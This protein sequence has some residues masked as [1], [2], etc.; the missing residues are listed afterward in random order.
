M[1]NVTPEEIASPSMRAFNLIQT[2]TQRPNSVFFYPAGLNDGRPLRHFAS[3]CRTFISCDAALDEVN[4]DL[5]AMVGADLIGQ[6]EEIVINGELGLGIEDHPEW[7]LRY[8]A[9]A[10]LRGYLETNQIIRQAGR[11]RA[12]PGANLRQGE[13]SN[14]DDARRRKSHFFMLVCVCRGFIKGLEGGERRVGKQPPGK[15]TAQVGRPERF[16]KIL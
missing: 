15:K 16:L 14:G 4:L 1:P 13:A 10:H 9:P 8:L 7:L 2:I 3:L 11:G 12:D 5:Q 6:P